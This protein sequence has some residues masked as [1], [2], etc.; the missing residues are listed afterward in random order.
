MR[1]YKEAFLLVIIANLVA[2]SGYSQGAKNLMD[3]LCPNNVTVWYKAG[4]LAKTEPG[5]GDVKCEFSKKDSMFRFYEFLNYR[6]VKKIEA[7]WIIVQNEYYPA[8]YDLK[9]GGKIATYLFKKE[10]GKQYFRLKLKGWDWER[11]FVR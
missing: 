2:L 8:K 3:K 10:L 6:W 9:I 5:P 1:K 4:S 11:T 7:N